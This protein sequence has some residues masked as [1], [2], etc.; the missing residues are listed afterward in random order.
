MDLRTFPTVESGDIGALADRA[1]LDRYIYLVAGCVGE[2]WTEMTMAHD[3]ALRH[4]DA[5]GVRGGGSSLRQGAAADQR[6][7]GRAPRP[8]K[9]AVLPA[10]G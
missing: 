7:P 4:W 8:A 2:F 9:G 10:R 3:R 1:A 5:A 6:A